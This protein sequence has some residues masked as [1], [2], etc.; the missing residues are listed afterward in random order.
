LHAVR[1][2]G[3]AIV[4]DIPMNLSR[5]SGRKEIVLPPGAIVATASAGPTKPPTPI[6]M[7]VRPA[8]IFWYALRFTSRY[9]PTGLGTSSLFWAPDP[10]RRNI[11]ELEAH[12]RRIFER[13]LKGE[14]Q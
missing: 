2:D 13:V 1:R 10:L 5:R 14:E 3:D 9:W 7:Y 4:I 8:L 12:M 11:L 6:S